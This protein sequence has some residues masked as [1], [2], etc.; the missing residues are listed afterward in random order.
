MFRF[1]G[2][3]SRVF[4][5]Y[6][7]SSVAAYVRCPKIKHFNLSFKYLIVDSFP[8]ILVLE[9][10]SLISSVAIDP[11]AML[12]SSL[13]QSALQTKC[14]SNCLIVETRSETVFSFSSIVL[15]ESSFSSESLL[16]PQRSL[17]LRRTGSSPQMPSESPSFHC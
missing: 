13:F 15:D 3:L 17:K 11:V 7:M 10:S 6:K 14:F 16:T 5:L 9:I 8:R 2:L 12:C 4:L 1:C